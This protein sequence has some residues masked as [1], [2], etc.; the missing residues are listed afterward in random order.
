MHA[1]ATSTGPL[2]PSPPAPSRE[3]GA[4]REQACLRQAPAHVAVSADPLDLRRIG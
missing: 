3:R 4:W 2:S 1:L